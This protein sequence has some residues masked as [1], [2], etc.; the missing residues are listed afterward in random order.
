ME[1]LNKQINHWSLIHPPYLY[2]F[3]SFLYCN[4]STKW[5]KDNC[6]KSMF[7]TFLHF[8]VRKKRKERERESSLTPFF[9][10][11]YWIIQYLS[12]IILE[13]SKSKLCCKFYF[14]I[15]SI[16]KQFKMRKQLFTC[17]SVSR[18]FGY[19]CYIDDQKHL[20]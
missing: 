16:Q 11:N 12:R 4:E 17:C 10:S 15:W 18:I 13:A 6:E 5:K 9:E 14:H 19:T 8:E 7:E 20:T 3:G 1:K 2:V